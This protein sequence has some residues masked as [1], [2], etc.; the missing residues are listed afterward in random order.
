MLI[1]EQAIFMLMDTIDKELYFT[2]TAIQDI[3]MWQG[4]AGKI[5][6][7]DIQILEQPAQDVIGKSAED[8]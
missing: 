6:I 1:L 3:K 8:G 7:V 4:F 2:K 5:V